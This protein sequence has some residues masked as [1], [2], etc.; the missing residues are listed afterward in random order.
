MI[1]THFLSKLTF[2][3]QKKFVKPQYENYSFANIPPTIFYL[4][5]REKS[6]GVL[7]KDCFGGRYPKPKK[8]VLFLIDAFGWYSWQRFKQKFKAIREITQK[9]VVTP[10]SALFPSTTAASISTINLGVLPSKHALYE[11]NIY[12]D[13]YS[14]VIQSLLFSPLGQKKRDKCLDLGYDPRFLLNYRETFYQKLKRKG[15]KSYQIV[16]KDYAHSAYNKLISRGGEIVSFS[17]LAEALTNL[18]LK[19]KEEKNKAYF[20]FYWGKIDSIGHEYGPFS[21][22]FQNEAANFWLLF[23]QIFISNYKKTKD[24]LFLFTADHG[25]VWA[26]PQKTF[27]LNKMAP[28]IKKYLKRNKKGEI[29]YPTGSPRDVFL[30]I[31]K[32]FIGEALEYLADKL[33]NIA[34]VLTI[35]K[36]KELGLFGPLSYSKKFLKRLGQILVLPDEGKYVWWYEKNKLESKYFGHHGGLTKKEMITF[37][38]VY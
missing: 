18:Q 13:E 19:I 22:Q 38:A 5:T 27:Y 35:D 1:N 33:K 10:I 4:L 31:K 20:Y 15:V 11:W 28:K 8:I 9:G 26:D 16:S 37:L 25:Q 29:I 2:L 30:H 36:A 23:E 24:A 7:S 3:R 34:L 12:F 21:L 6:K 14:T 17:T 32:E